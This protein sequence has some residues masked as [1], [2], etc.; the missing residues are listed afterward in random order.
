MSDVLIKPRREK[1]EPFLKG[2]G[3]LIINP[4]EVTSAVNL[5]RTESRKQYFL[6]NSRLF[7]ILPAQ[8]R[9]PFFLAG[10]MVG[11]PMAV[12]TMEKLVALGAQLFIIFGWCGSLDPSLRVGDI[13]LPTWAISE[14]GTS[15]HYPAKKRSTSSDRIRGLLNSHFNKCGIKTVEGPV[16]TTDAPYRETRDKVLAYGSE[17][18][19]G[20]DMEFSAMSALAAFREVEMAAVFLV[21]DELWRKEWSAGFRDK[22]FKKKSKTILQILIRCCRDIL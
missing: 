3:L 19:M 20:V 9:N 4:S 5:T 22:T 15:V 17:G 13:L 10:P 1:G 14:E 16:W 21:S 18:I 2:T 8:A 11:S 7:Q 12:M 6:Y